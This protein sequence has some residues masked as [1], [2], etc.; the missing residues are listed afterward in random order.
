[1]IKYYQSTPESK[2]LTE[3]DA[4]AKDCWIHLESPNPDEIK[5]ISE[6]TE[7]EESVFTSALDDEEV[8]HITFEDGIRI[9]FIDIPHR[10]DGKIFTVPL[11]LI[12]TS[13]H[14]VT[15]CNSKTLAFGDF[16]NGKIK[17]IDTSNH[18]RLVYQIMFN[19]ASRF[20]YHLKL[21]DK[22]SDELQ[23]DI[24]MSLKNREV[25]ELLELQKSLVFFSSSLNGNNT[26][27]HK[28]SF[29]M[30]KMPEEEREI[31]EDVIIETKQAVEMCSVS[32]E[33]LKSTMDAFGSVVNNNQNR[34][35]KFLTAITILFAVPTLFASL[36]G[37]NTGVP[38]QDAMWGFWVA[39]GI[40][41]VATAATAI[42]MFWKKM[43]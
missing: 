14:L 1:M 38:F 11:A 36:W 25:M 35:M 12:Q 13:Q 2:R 8:A 19:N 31:L 29:G 30:N 26:V 6:L 21:I 28:I 17:N 24:K 18:N 4:V 34:I 41:V 27:V 37:M 16:F 3:I 5:K 22:A 32:R 39:S 15:V 10:K 20:L 23:K 42:W 33:I 9:I 43:F 40:A 7:L